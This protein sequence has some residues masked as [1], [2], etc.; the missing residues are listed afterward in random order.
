MRKLVAYLLILMTANPAWGAV[1]LPYTFSAGQP[2]RAS[3]VNG[4][5]Q[6]LRDGINNHAAD[7]NAH[8]TTLEDVLLQ[9]NSTGS[10]P[11]DFNLTE[12]LEFRLENLGLA[13][14]CDTAAKGRAYFDTASGNFSVCDGTSWV[15]VAGSSYP[16]LAAVMSNGS[17]AGSYDLDMNLQEILNATIDTATNTI[18]TA[19]AGDLAATELNDALAELDSDLSTHASETSTHGVSGDLVGTSDTQTLTNKTIDADSNTISNIENADIKA[20]AAIALNK[21]AATTASRAMVTDASGFPSASSVTSTELGYLSGVTSG[22]Q[23]QLDAVVAGG[24]PLTDKGDLVVYDGDSNE[25]LPVG[26]D[27]WVLMADSAQSTGVEWGLI[28]ND[29]IDSSAAIDRSKLALGTASTV[30]INDGT[31]AMSE[32]ASLDE[33]RGGTAQTAYTKGDL[34]YSSAANTLS[35][36]GIGTTGQVLKVDAT[37]VPVWGTDEE[38]AGGS[39]P[40]TSKGDL[41]VHDGTSNDRLAVGANNT[42]M[43]ADSAQ[44]LGVKWATLAGANVSTT[45]SGNLAADDV[46]EAVNELQSDVDTRVY[47]GAGSQERIERANI[48]NTGSASISSQS[49]SW[50][51][52]CSRSSVGVV[53]CT[54][55]GSVFSSAPTCIVSHAGSGQNYFTRIQG[56]ATTTNVTA[57]TYSHTAAALADGSFTLMCMGPK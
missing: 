52:S 6:A 1:T 3:E 28:T 21:L 5:D 13:P 46:Q 54:I 14:T 40:T 4:N 45:P 24:L 51:S 17:S 57:V 8:N 53:S 56:F 50:L 18:V 20:A 11:I 49:G 43:I 2:V 35:K 10:T 7:S 15:A 38:G 47:N 55:A 22:I 37:G 44:T 26:T 42:V 33:T 25:R 31:G 32:E 36:L 39:L 48:V 19:A 9:D 34:L 16:N 23:A 30:L 41:I 29:S 27:S 12:A